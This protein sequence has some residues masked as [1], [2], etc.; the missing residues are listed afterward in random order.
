MTA[1]RGHGPVRAAGRR[2]PRPPAAPRADPPR[3]RSSA[4]PGRGLAAPPRPAAS[5]ADREP[6]RGDEPAGRRPAPDRDH[7]HHH[8]QHPA[9][10]T[11]Q[12]RR[13][14]RRAAPPTNTGTELTAKTASCQPRQAEEPADPVPVVIAVRRQPSADLCFLDQTGRSGRRPPHRRPP[15][16]QHR[17]RHRRPGRPTP[18]AGIATG[19]RPGRGIGCGVGSGI[20]VDGTHP[21]PPDESPAGE[22]S[23]GSP[24]GQPLGLGSRRRRRCRCW[25]GSVVGPPAGVMVG[26]VAGVADAHLVG[27]VGPD[28]RRPA[29]PVAAAPVNAEPRHAADRRR[30]PRRPGPRRR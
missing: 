8:Q 17:P 2:A 27:Q 10:G 1:T 15:P 5:A 30:S 6:G 25:S 13:S 28:G 29:T 12:R 18:G 14:R 21:S 26:L 22:S 9:A 19:R 20:R 23:A 3:S 4:R 7:R 24:S 16:H 11:E